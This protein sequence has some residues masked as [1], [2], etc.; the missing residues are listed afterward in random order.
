MAF[1]SQAMKHAHHVQ[2]SYKPNTAVTDW[3]ERLCSSSYKVT[4]YD[5]I[6]ELVESINLQHTGPSEAARA[7]RKKL[8]Y[9]NTHMQLRAIF[10]IKCLVENCGE[11]TNFQ[12]TFGDDTL[13]ERLR[14][15][16]GDPQTDPAVQKTLKSVL[17]GFHQQ[18]KEDRSMKVY[19]EWWD[20]IGG[21][22]GEEDARAREAYKKEQARLEK[23]SQLRLDEKFAR[24]LQG[25]EDE[26]ATKLREQ[27]RKQ[28]EL[29]A[30]EE[31]TRERMEKARADE[32]ARVEAAEKERLEKQRQKEE[33]KRNKSSFIGGSSSS[34]SAAKGAKRAPFNFEQEKPKISQAVAMASMHANGL[35]NA[36]QHVNREKESVA[37]NIRVQDQLVKLKD[38]RKQVIRYIQLCEVDK[39]GEYIG[40]LISSNDQIIAALRLYDRMLTKPADEDSDDDAP[41]QRDVA[42]AQNPSAANAAESHGAHVDRSVSD[43]LSPPPAAGAPSRSPD[44]LASD[45]SSM[46]V[47]NASMQS[48]GELD[49]LRDRQRTEIFKNNQRQGLPTPGIYGD[50]AGIDWT[51]TSL[52]APMDPKHATESGGD[53]YGQGNLSD[54]SDYESSDE[55]DYYRNREASSSSNAGNR[56]WK[57]FVNEDERGGKNLLDDD[58]FGDSAG[59]STPGAY[60]RPRAHVWAE[61]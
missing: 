19:A 54:F 42:A 30:A 35:V 23:E 22:R 5:G 39:E 3:V 58:P 4:E 7:L 59:V 46:R 9:G 18:Y 34:T 45:L 53:R 28:R 12:K 13:V 47:N 48:F 10:L 32:K 29:R 49:K 11:R 52:P 25:E 43:N 20:A 57:D 14:I 31:A 24:R 8:K 44:S 16:A 38:S 1:L 37:S 21:A 41:M 2:S 40:M 50:L 17:K 27:R 15:I 36:L 55:E 6:A 26:H 51:K 33:A 61:I 56:A 60:D